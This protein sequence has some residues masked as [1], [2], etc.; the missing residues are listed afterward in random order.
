[1]NFAQCLIDISQ[2]KLNKIFFKSPTT[3]ADRETKFPNN[4][5]PVARVLYFETENTIPKFRKAKFRVPRICG[6]MMP[7]SE[8]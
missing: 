4:H 2:L 1:M 5:G 6:S 7:L 8:I 3:R